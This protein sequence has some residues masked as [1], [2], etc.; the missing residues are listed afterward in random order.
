MNRG[1]AEIEPRSFSFNSP[2][3]ACNECTGIGS[4]LVV[5]PE[6]V[7]TDQD[8]TIREGAFVPWARAGTMTP[9]YASFLAA[10]ATKYGFSIDTPIKDLDH[11]HLEI[12]MHGAAGDTVDVRHVAKNGRVFRFPQQFEGII[13]SLE[14]RHR[15]TESDGNR[16]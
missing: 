14:R 10:I 13:A 4:R 3:G 6:L 1:L 5:D 12:I 2:H 11:E 9:W 7:I 16:G 15:D 8:L